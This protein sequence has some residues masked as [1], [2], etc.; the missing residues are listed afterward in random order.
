MDAIDE[1]MQAWPGVRVDRSQF[2]R[3]LEGRQDGDLAE[4]YL[5]CAVAAGDDRA[6]ALFDEH[7]LDKLPA[8]LAHMQLSADMLEEVGQR[9]R[10]KLIV[11]GK[12]DGYAGKGRLGGLVQVVAVRLAIDMLRKAKREV[13]A[14]RLDDLSS[15]HDP[16]LRFL[17]EKYRVVFSSAFERAI[18][19][20]T[21]RERNF[22]RLQVHGGLTVEQ[23]GKMYGVHRA[24]ATRL[25][26]QDPQATAARYPQTHGP[27]AIREPRGAR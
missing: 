8:A 25:A 10:H 4:R 7:Y 5:A 24:T 23:I 3:Y 2:E 18:A 6:L 11:D 1:A 17:K 15:P 19:D 16:E 21:S 20:L 13:G 26:H 14:D 12:L 27:G 9:V 22:L